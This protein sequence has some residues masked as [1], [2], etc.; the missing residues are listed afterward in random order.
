MAFVADE[1]DGVAGFD[2]ALHLDVDLGHQRA[3]GVDDAQ[4]SLP[5]LF[6][7]RGRYSMGTEDTGAVGRDFIQLIHEDYAAFLEAVHHVAVVDDL[8]AHVDGRREFVE[9]QVDDVDGTVDPGAESARGS[10]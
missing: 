3:G 4:S 1:H 5:A 6:P 8:T 7:D 10:Q 9:S 2:V